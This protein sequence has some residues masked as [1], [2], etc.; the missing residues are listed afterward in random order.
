MRFG[1]E[2]CFDTG[3]SRFVAVNEDNISKSLF[4]ALLWPL[5]SHFLF[6]MTPTQL[7]Q[8]SMYIVYNSY[9]RTLITSVFPFIALV[10][11]NFI[12]WRAVK[13]RRSDFGEPF[14]F[15]ST[16]RTILKR[17]K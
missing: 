11:F 3:S 10:I 5:L 14:F 9:I 4:A 17:L 13:K 16:V 6:Q 8:D 15:C 7:R 12:I 2:D 1:G